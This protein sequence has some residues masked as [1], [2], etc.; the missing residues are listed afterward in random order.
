MKNATLTYFSA[1][2]A[3]LAKLAETNDHSTLVALFREAAVEAVR[4]RELQDVRPRRLRDVPNR[5]NN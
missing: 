1:V 3:E 4:L 5:A 2:A